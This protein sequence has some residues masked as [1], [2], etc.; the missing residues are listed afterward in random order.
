MSLLKKFQQAFNPAPAK[1][2][3]PTPSPAPAPLPSPAKAFQVGNYTHY[4]GAMPVSPAG[5]QSPIQPLYTEAQ[6]HAAIRELRAMLARDESPETKA[7]LQ[8]PFATKVRSFAPW[9]QR[10][11][12]PKHGLASTSDPNT[13]YMDEGSYNRL[14]QRLTSPEACLLRPW[15]KWYYLKPLLPALQGKS[16]LEIGSAN[17]FFS[18]RFAELGARQ[19]TGIEILK[20]QAESARF[21]AEVLDLKNVSFL[22]TDFLLDLSIP[23]AD[24]VFLSEVHNHFLFPFLGLLR[25]VN[26]ARETLIFDTVAETTEEHG[27]TLNSGWFTGTDRM[28]YHS[29]HLSDGLILNYLNLA[30]LAPSRITRYKAPDDPAHVV[31]VIDTRGLAEARQARHYPEYLRRAL[32]LQFTGLKPA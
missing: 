6:I 11:D 23:P 25:L 1:A 9:Y 21:A 17:G 22:H 15:P 29:F 14:R 7:A 18:F 5:G 20:L 24:V 4:A 28:I 16:V 26:L 3:D 30:G 13:A 10:I 32:E 2:T 27:L 8:T 31:F 12:F 19:V